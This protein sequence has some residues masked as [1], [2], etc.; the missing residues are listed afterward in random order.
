MLLS[1]AD[2]ENATGRWTHSA[3]HPQACGP[4]RPGKV[5]RWSTLFYFFIL[6]DTHD[7]I[8]WNP[9]QRDYAIQTTTL[10]F[11]RLTWPSS[12]FLK[13]ASMRLAQQDTETKM[14]P[15]T[16][17]NKRLGPITFEL[18]LQ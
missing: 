6:A 12:L 9:R 5:I 3:H 15:L 8:V 11:F 18:D 16:S 10:S 14:P 2:N 4:A 17:H 1:L 13:G 7:P